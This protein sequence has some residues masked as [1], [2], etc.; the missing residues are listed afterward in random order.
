ML[1]IILYGK[2]LFLPLDFVKF[3][4]ATLDFDIS[5]LPLLVC[6]NYHNCHSVR[7][8]DVL[9]KLLVDVTKKLLVST[10][11]TVVKIML[12]YL[13]QTNA[14]ESTNSGRSHHS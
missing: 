7:L 3:S 1:C 9:T 2:I 8:M 5:L 4:Y 11:S 12:L 6:D 14:T 13:E 10:C